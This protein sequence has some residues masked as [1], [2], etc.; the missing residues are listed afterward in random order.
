[1][2]H[3]RYTSPILS[4][5]L[6]EFSPL[7]LIRL[8]QWLDERSG[9]DTFDLILHAYT[10]G[11]FLTGLVH[12][13]ELL[14]GLVQQARRVYATNAV[15]HAHL[16][17]SHLLWCPSPLDP[18]Q[19]SETGMLRLCTFAHAHKLPTARYTK[20]RDLLAASGR[21][22]RL[23]VSMALHENTPWD[24]A[25]EAVIGSLHKIFSPA[26]CSF[27]GYLADDEIVATLQSCFACLAFFEPAVRANNT[28][29][30]AALEHSR[31]ITNLD[32]QSPPGFVHNATVFDIDQLDH[33]PE[34]TDG[35][36]AAGQQL[37]NAHNWT[38][39]L[40]QL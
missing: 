8:Q 21:P 39:L 20:V 16:P 22:Y 18:L 31:L 26:Q 17:E 13:G 11:E 30:W 24:G 1:L 29:A 15:I 10:P 3:S 19:P 4:I 25:M 12:P 36:A 28:T 34:Q 38:R 33:W 2:A 35:I 32:A 37:A 5:N 6:Q 40:E 23:Y 14:T 27:R 9:F 7:D